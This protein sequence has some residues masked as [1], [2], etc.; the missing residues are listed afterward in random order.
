MNSESLYFN[1]NGEP[2]NSSEDWVAR[3][4]E[5]SNSGRYFVRA[6]RITRRLFNPNIHRTP[7]LE[8]KRSG[9]PIF[10]TEEVSLKCFSDYIEFLETHNDLMYNKANS[11]RR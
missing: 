6:D 4:T 10:S 7:D 8:G 11:Y 5:F 1:K 9:R 3:K 2:C